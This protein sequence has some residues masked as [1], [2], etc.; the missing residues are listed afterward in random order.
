MLGKIISI[1]IIIAIVV[2]VAA[3]VSMT[4]TIYTIEGTVLDKHIDNS[5]EGSHYIVVLT[6]GET[7]EIQRQPF[8]WD[9]EQNPDLIYA[10]IQKN[11]TYRFSCWGWR[12]EM[13]YWYPNVIKI[14][15]LS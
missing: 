15:Q 6:N 13:F 10:Q 9:R 14:E 8:R 4:S 1:V 7:L 12:N 2:S 3:Y 5:K 11:D